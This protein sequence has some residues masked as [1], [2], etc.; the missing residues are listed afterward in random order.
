MLKTIYCDQDRFN[1]ATVALDV[2]QE[3]RG[4]SVNYENKPRTLHKKIYPY[5]L[6]FPCIWCIKYNPFLF[7]TAVLF[8]QKKKKKK[9]F[10]IDNIN[11]SAQRVF[12]AQ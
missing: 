5:E 2:H 11:Y 6:N 4:K 3:S 10:S 9:R 7:A 12:N 1:A 8:E